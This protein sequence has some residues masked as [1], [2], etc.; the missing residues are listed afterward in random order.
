MALVL[1]RLPPVKG[2]LGIGLCAVLHDRQQ[3][4][5]VLALRLP[6][7]HQ[8]LQAGGTNECLLVCQLAQNLTPGFTVIGPCLTLARSDGSV[9]IGKCLCPGR[10]VSVTLVSYRADSGIGGECGES[11]PIL[12]DPGLS[13]PVTHESG[14]LV[15]HGIGDS[16]PRL[17]LPRINVQPG[18]SVH[19][20]PENR[21]LYLP[22]LRVRGLRGLVDLVLKCLP[23][24]TG[25][26]LRC[27]HLLIESLVDALRLPVGGFAQALVAP[28]VPA[29]VPAVA[30]CQ[31]AVCV[32]ERLGFDPANGLIKTPQFAPGKTVARVEQVTQS[33]FMPC[34]CLPSSPACCAVS[35]L[36]EAGF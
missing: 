7:I 33:C 23:G 3:L 22:E 15:F 10:T 9:D 20:L 34:H 26:P 5:T 35:G 32:D 4:V 21:P 29:H 30:G 28:H 25:G 8:V 19:L 16:R 2:V 27:G 1:L 18:K 24:L 14:L 17:R 13:L 12:P 11:C 31:P 36:S 6:Q